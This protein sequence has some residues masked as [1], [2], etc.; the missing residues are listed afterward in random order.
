MNEWWLSLSALQQVMFVIGSATLLFMVAQIIMMLVGLGGHDVS[1]EADLSGLDADGSVDADV[2][3]LD[4]ADFDAGA[5]SADAADADA[6]AGGDGMDSH[7]GG[8]VCTHPEGMEHLHALG[9]K[10]LSLRCIIAFCCFGAWVTFIMDNYMPWYFAVALG[11]AAGFVAAV[12]MALIMNEMMKLQRD[13]TI[14]FKNCVG[15]EGEVYLVIPAARGGE[16]K[17]NV[18]VQETLAEFSAV[19]D[20]DEPIPTGEKVRVVKVSG[21]QLVVERTKENNRQSK[22]PI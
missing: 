18:F 6:A 16:G 11:V 8:E 15:K 22:T 7:D 5:D 1:T 4:T 21:N 17:V 13:G 19:T 3:G 12:I 2:T 9:L 14:R 10:L 20:D